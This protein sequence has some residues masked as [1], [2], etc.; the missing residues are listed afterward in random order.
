M[1]IL[2]T[3][4]QINWSHPRFQIAAVV[5]NVQEGVTDILVIFLAH[6]SHTFN[7]GLKI[8]ATTNAA[9]ILVSTC[10]TLKYFFFILHLFLFYIF[11]KAI[12]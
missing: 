5:T 6:F 4:L 3:Y 10:F 1:S 2:I 9:Y 7:G 11:N 8:I 12:F